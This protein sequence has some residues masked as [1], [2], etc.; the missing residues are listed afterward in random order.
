LFRYDATIVFGRF[1]WTDCLKMD[2]GYASKRRRRRGGTNNVQGGG[3]PGPALHS[4][5]VSP[6]SQT[7]PYGTG[8]SPPTLAPGHGAGRDASNVFPNAPY[9]PVGDLSIQAQLRQ[10]LLH[11]P[12]RA[13][14]TTTVASAKFAHFQTISNI[15]R[16]PHPSALAPECHT[17][18]YHTVNRYNSKH[19]LL[20]RIV[21]ASASA[22]TCAEVCEG[23]RHFRHPNLVPLHGIVHTTEFVLGYTD[24]I[25][26]YRYVKGGART[27]LDS[28]FGP[29]ALDISE[30]VVWAIACQMVSLLRMFHEVD[31]AV[32]GVHLSKILYT[33]IGN[34]VVFSGLGLAELEAP[35][36]QP[37]QEQMA[38]DIHALGL[39]LLRL[40][41]RSDTATG[42][43]VLQRTPTFSPGF[44]QFVATCL[45][46]SAKIDELCRGLGER[47]AMELGHQLG[48]ADFLLGECAKEVHNGRLMRLLVKLNF[49][50]ATTSDMTGDA[51]Q[52]ALRLFYNYVFNQVDES[53]RVRHDWGH[54]YFALNKLDTG[55]ED[56]IQLI[57][58]DN[59]ST[60]LVIS[61]RDLRALLNKATEIVMPPI[62]A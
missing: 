1:L 57:S 47:S 48:H 10:F 40:A 20:R 23:Y 51:E 38:A 24:I 62:D 8:V 54:V 18:V 29:E 44:V 27:L 12:N 13:A 37:V 43:D 49:I 30:G 14:T 52:F 5:T 9:V 16:E 33:D 26:E 56:L 6:P 41:T 11:Q 22:Q 21:N 25:M 61:Y 60:L 31:V 39:T 15:E 58:T 2:G 55:S 36:T 4:N 28:F 50:Y 42:I 32:R 17:Q 35:T 7:P 46:G 19:V 45:D 53:G 59:D 3:P 34:R